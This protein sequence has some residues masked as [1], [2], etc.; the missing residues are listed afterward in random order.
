MAFSLGIISYTISTIIEQIEDAVAEFDEESDEIGEPPAE[1]A[2]EKA[3][4]EVFE[5]VGTLPKTAVDNTPEIVGE[6]FD[7]PWEV[8]PITLPP[9]TKVTPPPKYLD[10]TVTE[11]FLKYNYDFDDIPNT[12]LRNDFAQ[13]AFQNLH[14]ETERRKDD[15]TKRRRRQ[16][17]LKVDAKRR[18]DIR[19]LAG[20]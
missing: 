14:K 17:S 20:N 6:K 8:A 9:E 11:Y 4:A 3:A 2:F 1:I 18:E 5:T 16:S 19:H 15:E 7:D 12:V 10:R 13:K